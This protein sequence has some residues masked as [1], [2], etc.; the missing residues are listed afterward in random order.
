MCGVAELILIVQLAQQIIE[1]QSEI[2]TSSEQLMYSDSLYRPPSS[3]LREEADRI[4]RRD[5][6]IRENRK[7]LEEFHRLIKACPELVRP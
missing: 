1:H 7:R 2:S 6:A 4:D 3:R 5:A